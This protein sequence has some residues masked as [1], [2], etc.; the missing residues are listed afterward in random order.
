MSG[1]KITELPASTTPLSGSEIVPL[2]QGGVTKR[3]TVTQ[4]GTVTAT[5]TTTPRTLPDRFADAVSVKDFGAVGDG[6]ADDTAAFNSAHA[7]LP[8]NGGQIYVPPGT[9]KVSTSISFT[10][11]TLLIGAGVSAST[12]KTSSAIADVIVFDCAYCAVQDL[13]FDASVTRTSGS[14][15]H[16]TINCIRS[17]VRD[18]LMLNGF[19]GITAVCADTIWIENGD[20][21]DT[22]TGGYGIRFVGDG[23]TPGGNDLYVNHVTMSG[24]SNRATA[25]IQITNNGAINITDC[26]IIRHGTCLLINPANGE[27]A[28]AI[29]VLNSY[30]DTAT[31]GVSINPAAGGT[32]AQVRVADCWMSA[33]SGTGVIIG[34]TGTIL[35]VEFVSPHIF[36]NVVRGVFLGGGSDI[37]FIGGGIC[38]NTGD[39]VTISG[40][41]GGFHFLGTRI[42]NGYGKG[43]NA[44]GITIGSGTGNNFSIIG[45]DMRG[46]TG[47]ALIDG[48]NGTSKRIV[49]NLGLAGST[50]AI[51]VGA[52]PF[53]YT[54]GNRPETVYVTGGTVSLVN[55]DGTNVHQASEIS[56]HLR[57]GTSMTVTYSSAPFMNKTVH[58]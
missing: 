39:G 53:T 54:A 33:H 14:Y 29:Y 8:A 34:A 43:A 6:V 24:S 38:G 27:V 4:I 5:G 2:V 10:K 37:H 49:Q 21:F 42:G 48:S 13:G 46:N 55:V 41:V 18:F 17:R 26:D 25:G 19:T 1:I 15:I 23:V 45:C 36:S 47:A 9:Y 57:S 12:L 56:V 16:I 30:F 51:T 22:Q 3:A 20:I 35:G 52:S 44:T 7:S 31:N 40:N 50:S 11:P 32:V 28:S 58:D